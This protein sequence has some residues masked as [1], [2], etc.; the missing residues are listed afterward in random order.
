MHSKLAEWAYKRFGDQW[1]GG[2]VPPGDHRNKRVSKHLIAYVF[3]D[4]AYLH[5]GPP[6]APMANNCRAADARRLAWFI[7]WDW[8]ACGTWFGLKRWIWY[9]ALGKKVA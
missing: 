6:D 3:D 4:G 7:L 9:K 8:W 1:G 2:P 5:I